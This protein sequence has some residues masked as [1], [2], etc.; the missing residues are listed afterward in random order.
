[1]NNDEAKVWDILSG[2]KVW[3]SSVDE[4][5]NLELPSELLE[6]MGWEE[7]DTLHID[8]NETGCIILSKLNR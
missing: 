8:V 5:G 2:P 7:G 4:E 1:M 3:T 6:R